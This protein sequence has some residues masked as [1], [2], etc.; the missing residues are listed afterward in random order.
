M[1]KGLITSFLATAV[2]GALAFFFNAPKKINKSKDKTYKNNFL[3]QKDD[4]N[5]LFI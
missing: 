3:T 5:D 2:V 4:A 1:K